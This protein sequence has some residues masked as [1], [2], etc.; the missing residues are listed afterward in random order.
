MVG[1]LGTMILSYSA[2]QLS[3]GSTDPL[4]TQQQSVPLWLL[5]IAGAL[6]IAWP[7]AERRADEPAAP[8]WEGLAVI[9]IVALAIL[10]RVPEI[11]RVPYALQGDETKYALGGRLVIDGKLFRPFTTFTDGHWVMYFSVNALFM[12]VFGQTVEAI[13]L[14]SAVIGVLSVL[15][16]YG[17][18]RQ[19]WGQRAALIAAALLAT[20]HY[21]IHYSRTAIN[22]IYDALF[23]ALVFGW[24]WRG[25]LTGRRVP[26]LMAAVA[27]GLTQFFYVGGRLIVLEV[28]VLGLFWLIR[29]PR[30]L[31]KRAL[32][33]GLSIGVFATIA[34]PVV[35]FIQKYPN[36]YMTRLNQSGIF[37]SGWLAA[38]A[39]RRGV[40][41]IE[42][43]W[44]QVRLSVLL[45]TQGPDRVFYQGQSLLTPIMSVLAGLSL[46]YL[47][48][49]IREGPS[50]WTWA[51]LTMILLFGSVLVIGPLAASQRLL[52]I[53][54]VLYAAIA[55]FID[56]LL[57]RFER[58]WRKPRMWNAIGAVAVSGLMLVD[59]QYYFAGYVGTQ[60]INSRDIEWS[61]Q[62]GQYLHQIEERSDPAQWQVI[63]DSAPYLYCEHTNIRFLAPQL[64]GSARTT[65]GPLESKDL[66]P[67]PGVGLIVIVSPQRLDDV[68]TVLERYPAAIQGDHY[69]VHGALLFISLEIPPPSQ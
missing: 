68:R 30:Q 23:V 17:L 25:W 4:V 33:I 18:V 9:G 36:D 65:P 42:I 46:V 60:V 2:A 15:A 32:D 14:H 22:A 69:G 21:H 56:R 1:L 63:C 3:L 47:I 44:D 67:P 61:M 7:R 16:T 54:P 48:T 26:W 39:Q 40:G 57:G 64:S 27:I 28:I 11:D 12:R 34:M 45:F 59:A 35:Y 19:L 53:T 49:R 31:R 20:F 10:L 5:S 50:F 29:E 62:I 55:V 51:T 58:V 8:R 43:L 52:G 41:A 24:L 66:S 37:Q 13:R 38:E 6:V